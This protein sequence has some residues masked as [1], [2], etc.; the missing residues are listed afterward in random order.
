MPGKDVGQALATVGHYNEL[1]AAGYDEGFCKN[2]KY[3][4]PVQDDPFC[5]SHMGIGLCL[6]TMGGACTPTTKRVRTT[7]TSALSPVFFACG[8]IQGNRFAVKYPFKLSG[9]SHAMAMYYGYVAGKN[10][11][12]GL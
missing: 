12:A 8:N 10:A 9:A 6:T 7:T 1:C 4:W 11:A 3:L 2:S 5:A